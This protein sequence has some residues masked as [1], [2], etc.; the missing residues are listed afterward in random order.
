MPF[1]SNPLNVSDISLTNKKTV[2]IK[3]F[4]TLKCT[5]KMQKSTERIINTNKLRIHTFSYITVSYS[6]IIMILLAV[7]GILEKGKRDE[8]INL[9]YI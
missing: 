4:S 7:I 1:I 3:Y 8:V 9:S 6:P 2:Q 5:N